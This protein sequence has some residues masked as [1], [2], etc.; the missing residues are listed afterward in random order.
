M[1]IVLPK[2]RMDALARRPPR[3]TAVPVCYVQRVA[4]L[5]CSLILAVAKLDRMFGTNKFFRKNQRKLYVNGDLAADGT[6]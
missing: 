3:S 4:P 2:K 6:G 5:R 1:P